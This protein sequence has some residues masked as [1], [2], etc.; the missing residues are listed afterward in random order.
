M[1]RTEQNR[2]EEKRRAEKRREEN[3]LKV[4]H[5]NKERKIL[6]EKWRKGRIV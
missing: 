2:V 4:Q 5:F 6:K 3:F 1:N